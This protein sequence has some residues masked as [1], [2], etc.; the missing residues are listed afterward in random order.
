M[1]FDG[2]DLIT[3]TEAGQLTDRSPNAIRTLVHEGELRYVAFNKQ[4]RPLLSKTS[5][6]EWYVTHPA[7][8]GKARQPWLNTLDALR[9][10]GPASA[11]ELAAYLGLHPGNVRK[12]LRILAET[13][14]VTRLSDGQW[15]TT[16]SVA[17]GD[18]RQDDEGHWHLATADDGPNPPLAQSQAAGVA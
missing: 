16:W 6:L 13:R 9:C 7:K 5:V 3:T 2:D 14:D 12:H 1:A 17:R 15:A 10:L 18:V 8:P 11:D 4:R